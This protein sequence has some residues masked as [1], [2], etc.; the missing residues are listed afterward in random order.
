LSGDTNAI[1]GNFS[2]SA[3]NRAVSAIK[4]TREDNFF[5]LRNNDKF[6]S[7]DDDVLGVVLGEYRYSRGVELNPKDPEMLA[8]AVKMAGQYQKRLDTLREKYKDV[9]PVK[10]FHGQ[11]GSRGDVEGIKRS[12]FT[13]PTK[14]D[15]FH[16]E[17]YVGAPSFTKDL[18]LGFRGTPFG[19]TDPKNYVV[20]EI[21]YAD[22]VF[23]KINMAPEKYD[24]KDMNTILRAV[25]GA[26]GVV[27]PISLPRAGFLETEDMMVEAEKLRVKGKNAKLRSAETDVSEA[28]QGGG[29]DVIRVEVKKEEE[30]VSEYMKTA[31]QS[32]DPK[33][34]MKLAYMSYTG[35]KDLM[36]SYIGM[37]KATSTKTG[38]GQ[39]YQ[40]AINFFADYSGIQ[41]QMR[42][43]GDILWDGG[44][45]Q[46]AQ[47]LYELSDKLKKFQQSEPAISTAVDEA[48]RTKPL[49][50]VRKF[51]PKLAKGGLASRR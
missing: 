37:G 24:I 11:G 33:E 4:E 18:N 34:R 43:V 40:A 35:I 51:V 25:T 14:R 16:S 32:N 45:K 2:V 7:V 9:P 47:N 48:K 23:N 42:E 15:E 26:P 22:Y 8:D 17:M 27:R 1:T 49:D 44:A 50:E 5:K 6:A 31:R 19:G 20:T 41:R 28:L 3:R 29:K 46:K 36:N 13:D 38:L 10:L 39:Q 12:G 21:P 30:L